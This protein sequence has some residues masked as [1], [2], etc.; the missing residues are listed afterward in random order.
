[1]QISKLKTCRTKNMKRGLFIWNK[2]FFFSCTC[3]YSYLITKANFTHSYVIHHFHV[4]IY[5]M[6]LV[7]TLHF[8]IPPPFSERKY[9]DQSGPPGWVAG[10]CPGFSPRPWPLTWCHHSYSWPFAFHSSAAV[11]RNTVYDKE[12]WYSI[13]L[14]FNMIIPYNMFFDCMVVS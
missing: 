10:S 4:K 6:A 12:Q 1:M 13:S 7:H 3:V 11:H 14:Y 8:Q 9:P 5:Q 2:E